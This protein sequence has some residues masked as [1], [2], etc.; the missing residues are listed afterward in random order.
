MRLRRIEVFHAVYVDYERSVYK[1]ADGR[2]SPFPY[3]A[4]ENERW[5]VGLDELSY[6]F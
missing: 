3:F 4:Y 6:T 5:H 2:W 1:S